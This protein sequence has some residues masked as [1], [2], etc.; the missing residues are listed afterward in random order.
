MNPRHSH[1]SSALFQNH[2][3]FFLLPL[4][5]FIIKSYPLYLVIH[6]RNVIRTPALFQI[7]LHISRTLIKV[8]QAYHHR[9][10]TR[11]SSFL[12][13]HPVYIPQTLLYK[14]NAMCLHAL[15]HRSHA[16]SVF[17]IQ[18]MSFLLV[19]VDQWNCHFEIISVCRNGFYLLSMLSC[20]GLPVPTWYICYNLG[21]DC[22][23]IVSLYMVLFRYCGR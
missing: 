20:L 4:A 9:F 16:C 13:P 15:L 14:T 7:L 12:F 11:V 2:L 10:L 23:K 5:L 19:Y 3:R 1:S 22:K 6:S 17:K 21:S 8:H 18:F